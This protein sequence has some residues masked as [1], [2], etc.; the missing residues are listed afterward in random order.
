M[1]WQWDVQVLSDGKVAISSVKYSSKYL[2]VDGPPAIDKLAVS[3][4][5]Y[6][7]RWRLTTS[8]EANRF[9]SVPFF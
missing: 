3:R 7:S 9:L 8:A 4:E 6:P 5:V 1:F 2:S